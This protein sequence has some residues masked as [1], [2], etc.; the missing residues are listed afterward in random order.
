[1][2]YQAA[3]LLSLLGAASAFPGMSGKARE[4][5]LETMKR[6]AGAEPAAD[7][8]LAERDLISTV[9]SD[10]TG[11]LGSVASN[12][13]PSDKRPEPGYT[14]QAPTSTDSRGPCPGTYEIGI[15]VI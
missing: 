4:E 11:L 3:A 10:V 8:T 2:K 1:M 6:S 14:F 9:I 12:V 13:S 15:S 7:A 5:M